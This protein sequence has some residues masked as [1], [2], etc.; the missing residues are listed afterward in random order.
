MDS[1]AL[2]ERRLRATA[3]KNAES[4]RIARQRAERDLLATKEALERK[5]EELQQ[6]REWFQVTLASIA[7]AVITT[8]V[9]GK[10]TY[11]NPVAESMTGW[12]SAQAQGEPLARVFQIINEYTR[13]TVE[14]PIGKVLQTGKTV[15][16][17]NHTAL[18]DRNGRVIAIEDSA[19][20]IRDAQGNIAGAVMVFRDVSS[21]RQA[22]DSVRVSE[23]RLRAIFDQAAVGIVVADVNGRFLQANQKFCDV[24]GYSLDELRQLTFA[25]TTHPEDVAAMRART[26]ALFDGRVSHSAFERRYLR[27]DGAAIWGRTTLTL[28][29]QAHGEAE[30]CIGVVEDVTERRETER[31]L[32]DARAYAAEIGRGL[33]AI[34]ESSDDA[35]ISKT[36]EGVITSWNR[37][38]E[39][40]FGY[41][42]EEVIG[43]SVTLLIPPNQIDEEPAILEKLRRGERIDHYETV[44]IR[45]DGTVL[46]VSLTVSP[47]KDDTGTIIGA[48]KIARDI[49]QRKREEE[50]LHQEIS[51]REAAEA[52]LRAA[53]QRK[54]EFLATLAHELRNPL[55]PIRQAALIFKAPKATEAQKRWS[56]EVI[57]RQVQHMSLLLEDLLDISRITHGTLELRT[58]VVEL[59]EIVQAA[60]E[61]ARPTIDAKGHDFSTE[62]PREPVHFLADPLRLAQVLSN[63]LTNAAKY[64]EPGGRIR[65]RASCTADTVTIDV[66]D[67]GI[68]L[69]PHAL[70][71][72]FTMFSQVAA[73]RDH[74]Q[75]GLG[76]GLALAK[77]L[78]ELHGGEI[79]ARSAGIGQGSDFIVRLPLRKASVFAKKQPLDSISAQPVTRRVLVA[80]DNHDAGESLASLLRLD[81]HEVTVVH[82]GQEA[83]A[84][85]AAVQPEVALLDI[86]MPELTGY[87]VARRVRQ[88]SLGR[89]VTLIAVTGWGQNRDKAQALAAGFN[90]HFTKP[91]ETDRLRELLRSESLGN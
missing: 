39:R 33:A 35:I 64:T 45:K 74:S 67:N 90:H 24:L 14:N 4:I 2:E 79:E 40:L 42:A 57:S 1:D 68:G 9:E 41:T 72:I 17:P 73:S 29:R 66:V 31:A 77:G 52:A 13:Q 26:R 70:T 51:I 59:A 20:P 43:K 76:I 6:Q 85:F 60:V 23:E 38:A 75:G 87:E 47:I 22:E 37:G 48:S 83:L 78:T 18:T 16:L 55:A 65:L 91:V 15:G 44:R 30:W 81:G 89:A 61:G 25:H 3:L 56:S 36:L 5:T 84:A 7:D 80:D 54:D 50:K 53:D 71:N 11:L 69:P 49:T 10:V 58:E 62:L 88:G 12:S 32:R 46:H 21:R 28:L 19:A 34:V 63:L 27:K 8:D 82:T 86:G